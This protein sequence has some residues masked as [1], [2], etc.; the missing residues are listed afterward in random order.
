M[1]TP[2]DNSAKEKALPIGIIFDKK[3]AILKSN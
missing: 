3:L 2:D 1:Q